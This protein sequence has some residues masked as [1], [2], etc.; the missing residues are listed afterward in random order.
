MVSSSLF[1]ITIK[2][3]ILTKERIKSTFMI[4]QLYV[5]AISYKQTFL[6]SDFAIPLSYDSKPNTYL[7]RDV[8]FLFNFKI[9]IDLSIDSLFTFYI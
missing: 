8:A 2:K 3:K 6:S 4:F 5:S 7:I 9:G 1:K